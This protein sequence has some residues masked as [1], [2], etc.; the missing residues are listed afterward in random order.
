MSTVVI[1]CGTCEKDTTH[2]IKPVSHLLHWIL[3]VLTGGIW[4]LVY[5]VALVMHRPQPKCVECGNEKFRLSFGGYVAIAVTI[6]YFA[7]Q[8]G[9]SGQI[10]DL[11]GFAVPYD[12]GEF[13]VEAKASIESLFSK[14][15]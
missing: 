15:D 5:A 6:L 3:I 10:K 1:H 4:L 7:H 12:L 9:I 2:R 11:T 8:W 13:I 14:T